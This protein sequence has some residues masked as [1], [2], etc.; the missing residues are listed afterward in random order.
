MFYFAG[1]ES[2]HAYSIVDARQIN[3]RRFVRLRNPW[4]E[5]E[6]KDELSE[7]WTEWSKTIKNKRSTSS[8][9]DGVFW[10]RMYLTFFQ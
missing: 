8:P 2:D 7:N 9:N 1:L 6:W 10:M 5:K 3:S 4:G